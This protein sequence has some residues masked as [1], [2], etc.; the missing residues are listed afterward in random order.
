MGCTSNDL[1]LHF[2]LIHKDHQLGIVEFGPGKKRA[3][4]A[5]YTYDK[6]GDLSVGKRSW[7]TLRKGPKGYFIAKKNIRHY[8]HDFIKPA[9]K[10][11]A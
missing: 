7:S 8:L 9:P 4:I 11:Y 5:Y 2:K 1:S 6:D 3:R 10:P